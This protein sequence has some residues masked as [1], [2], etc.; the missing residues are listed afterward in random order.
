[1]SEKMIAKTKSQIAKKLNKLEKDYMNAPNDLSRVQALNAMDDMMESELLQWA[2]L[3]EELVS[4]E[5]ID[6]VESLS[7]I[8]E[9]MQKLKDVKAMINETRVDL[10]VNAKLI[11]D[12]MKRSHQ[13]VEPTKYITNE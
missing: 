13:F 2:K 8:A 5:K 3:S 7:H 9:E 6:N 12:A 11:H 1:M 4:D 10:L